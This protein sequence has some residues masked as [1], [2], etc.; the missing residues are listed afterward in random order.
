MGK[1]SRR[2]FLK[3]AAAGAGIVTLNAVLDACGQILPT[4][5]PLSGSPTDSGEQLP[6]PSLSPLNPAPDTTD[7]FPAPTDTPLT[8]PDMVVTRGGEPELLVRQAVGA[9]G[10]MGK[11]VPSGAN[12]VIKPN[13]CVAYH[14]YEYAATTNPW[15]V[16]TLVKMCLEAGAASVKVMDFP[17]GGTQQKAYQESGIQEQVEAAG[18]EMVKMLTYRYV[19]TQIP[20]AKI[21][22]SSSVY[23]AILNADVLIN[24]PIAKHHEEARLTLGMKNL[25]GVIQNR[26]EL[27]FNLGQCIADLNTLIKPQLTIIDAVRILTQGGPTGGNLSDVVKMDTVIASA[28]VV[29]ADSYATSLFGMQPEDLDYI[30]RGTQ[31]GLGRSD[32]KN[33]NIQEIQL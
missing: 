19:P 25:M 22:K 23:D 27:H 6:A 20:S 13:I 4:T 21:L 32:L 26:G 14:T 10:G 3:M 5:S 28:D 12:V 18:G 30:V 17:F 33:L 15:V 1:Y 29:A 24:A 8:I 9:L 31:M 11:F 2:D 7:T 16:G